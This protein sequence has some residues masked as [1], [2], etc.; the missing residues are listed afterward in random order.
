MKRLTNVS[1]YW[2]Q[3]SKIRLDKHMSER[4]NTNESYTLRAIK[5][6]PAELHPDAIKTVRNTLDRCV[7]LL[8]LT[9]HLFVT[10]V[11]GDSI[12]TDDGGC[13]FGVYM[14]GIQHIA[15]AGC[16]PDEFPASEKEWLYYLAESVVHECI[17][18]QNELAGTLDTESEEETE[19]RTKEI[20]DR[21]CG[22]RR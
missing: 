9:P 2:N 11:A 1:T 22:E 17:H 7:E 20:I 8:P 16:I 12:V 4:I 6:G 3:S 14:C 18:Y 19:L 5:S 15:L 13:G 10:L 21:I